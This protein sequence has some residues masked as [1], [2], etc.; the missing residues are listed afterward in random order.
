MLIYMYKKSIYEGF[1]VSILLI[2]FKDIK[3]RMF[4]NFLKVYLRGEI[5]VE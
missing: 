5:I 1:I 4:L 2:I 3:E